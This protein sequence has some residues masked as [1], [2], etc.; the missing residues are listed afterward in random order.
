[1]DYIRSRDSPELSNGRRTGQ[2][3]TKHGVAR[4]RRPANQHFR[5]IR[6]RGRDLIRTLSRPYQ[7]NAVASFQQALQ[8]TTDCD[9]DAVDFGGICF[10]DYRDRERPYGD[11]DR[12]QLQSVSV[13]IPIFPGNRY[14]VDKIR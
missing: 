9:G 4:N 5:E 8:R 13:H 12:R 3:Y 10:S 7:L 2:A 14:N 1:M 6:A 11:A